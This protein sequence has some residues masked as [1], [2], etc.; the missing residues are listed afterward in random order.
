MNFRKLHQSP[1][2]WYVLAAGIVIVSCAKQLAPTG[3]SVPVPAEPLAV[4]KEDGSTAQARAKEIRETT[5]LTLADGLKV[6]L[7]ASDS[8]AP[9]PIA[10]SIDDQG[11][12]YLTRTNR[13]K[14]SEFDIRGHRDWM[15]P[16]IALQSVE[17]RRAFLRKTFDPAKSKENEWLKDLNED[18]SHDWHDLA[19]EKD[20]V[21]RLEDTDKDG[22]ADVSTRILS[23]FFEEV[24]D[25]AG[26]LLV[27]AKDVFVGIAPDMWRL[28]DTNGD[29]ILD[30]K[31]SISHGFGVHIGFGG[32]GMS[33]A[34][35]GPDGRI[36][37]GIGDI[38]ANLV[39]VTGKKY[40]YPNE[41][42]I[43][44]SNP[45]GTDFEVFASGLRNTHEF[46]FDEYGNLISSDNDGDHPG[47]SERLVHIV[48]GS[49]AGWRSNWQYGKYTDPK[50]NSYKVW[51][52]E[53]MF[54]PHQ[55]G[56]AAYFIPPIQNFHNGP[57]G[58][59]YN[60]GTALGSAW[61]NKFFLVE[62]V[63]NPARSPIWSFGLKPKGA[64]FVLDG[65]QKVLGGILPTGIRF[66]PD[67]ALYVADWL[68]GWDTKNAG[69]VWRLD[70]T[71]DKNDMKALRLET[72]RLMQLDYASQKENALF[73]LLSN[74]DM[75][76]RQKAQ[77]ELAQRGG[78]GAAE[79]GRAIVQT[80]NQ[81]ARVHG[82]WGIGQLARENKSYASPLLALLKDKDN[83][84]VAQAAKVLGDAAVPEAGP[85]LVPLL[86]SSN[87]RVQ[88]FGAQA[89]GRVDY[90]ESVPALLKMIE[91]NKD[92][93]LYLR[94]AAVVAL[95][96]LNQVEP[97]IALA[98]HPNKSLRL[99]AVLVLRRW[100]NENVR[101]F[102]NDKDEYIVAEAARAI[103]DDLSIPGALPDLAAT[104]KETRF[105]SEPL[106][107]RAINASLRVGGDP[108]L[109]A[110]LDFAKRKDVNKE[111]RTEA[112][113]ALGTWANPSVLDR[114]D[115]RYRG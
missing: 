77:L 114:V 1:R 86:T 109:Q 95:A 69:R 103:N 18:G 85:L 102:L 60:P 68:N 76:I 80:T 32:H 40:S 88:F 17:D 107:R 45:D 4:V 58:M 89:L 57:T 19:V 13:Q 92:E 90:K 113:A 62:F 104:L 83:E 25:V 97:I 100:G 26:A 73:D 29:G 65:E 81:L 8:L 11:R 39:D 38:G 98:N 115:G 10:M 22:I 111:L 12:V 24:S 20:E 33:G 63:G 64:S 101:L 36:Y 87:P 61:K 56:Q 47:E 3:N 91:A 34:I 16:S 70:V 23:D 84:I 30:R 52:D 46:V 7:W 79:F 74:P 96:R 31:T 106:L 112:L 27:R 53:Q 5:S 51:M 110:L 108:Q 15:T 14:N 55:A 49:D 9:D 94:H 50:N 41:G 54:K 21:W 37:W 82:V 71:E 105:T 44:R 35:E 43:V 93:D 78:K 99:A 66:G 67:G 48:D 6:D 2:T 28:T 72:Q 75:R 59:V 42:V